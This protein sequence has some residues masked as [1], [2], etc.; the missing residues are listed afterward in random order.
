MTFLPR[1]P[2]FTPCVRHS[3]MAH[4]T[5]SDPVVSKKTRLSDKGNS[6]AS[7][8]TVFARMALGKQ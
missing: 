5:V 8:S 3:L 1:P 6:E 7:F 4:S 2:T